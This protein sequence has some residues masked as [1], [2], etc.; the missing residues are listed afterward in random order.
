[1]HGQLGQ[2]FR[3]SQHKA[4]SSTSGG[5]GEILGI[6]EVGWEEVSCWSTKAAISETRKDVEKVTTYGL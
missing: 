2:H 5:H 6:L 3:S 4:H 1:L